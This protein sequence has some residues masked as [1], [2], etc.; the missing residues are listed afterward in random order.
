MKYKPLLASTT[1]LF[2]F[3]SILWAQGANPQSSSAAD[4]SGL[5]ATFQKPP[6]DSR[7]MMRWWWFGSAVTK[8]EI[9]KEMRLMRDGGIGGIEVQPVYPLIPDDPAHGIANLRFLSDEFI[10]ALHFASEKS[11]ELGMRIDLTLGSGWPYGGPDIPIDLAAGRLRCERIRPATGSWRVPLPSMTAGEKIEAIFL[12]WESEKGGTSYV[13]FPTSAVSQGLLYVPAD[14]QGVQEV[15]FFISSRTG[16]QVKRPA[17]GSEGY[18]VDHYSRPAL[19]HYLKTVGDRLLQ[20]FGSRP[21]HAVFCDS[22]EVYLSDWSGDFLQEFSK[23]RGY[24]LKLHLPALVENIGEKTAAVRRD[25]GKTLTE[26]ANE[27]FVAPL[28]DWAKQHG[29]QLRMQCY[30]IPPVTLSSNTL[31]DLPE[32]EGSQWKILRASRWASSASHLYGRPVTSSETWTWLHSPVFRATPLDLKAEADLHF[33]QGINQLIGHGWPYT[34]PGVEYPGWRFYAAGVYNEKNPWWI[35]MPDLSL[36]LQR[37][38]YLLRQGKPSMDIA[39][40][41]PNDDAWASFTSGRVNLLEALGARLGP[42]VVARILEAGYGFDFVD[43]TAIEQLGKVENRALVMGGNRYKMVILPGVERIPLPVFRKLDE[44]ARTGGIVVA[45]RRVPAMAPGM[46][47]LDTDHQEV[48][49]ISQRLFESPSAAGYLVQDEVNELGKRLNGLLRPDMTLTPPAPE[50]GFVH[51][52]TASEEIYFVANSSNRRHTVKAAFRVA[53]LQPEWWDPFTGSATPAEAIA[54][55]QGTTTVQLDLE[56]YGSRILVF[57]KSVPAR[58]VT[59]VA[60]A[61]S[62]PAPLEL[63]EGWNI[64]FGQNEKTQVMAQLRSWTDLEEMRYFSGTATYEKDVIVPQSFLQPGIEVRLDFGEGRA[65]PETPARNGMQAWYEAPV[66]EAAVVFVN[67]QRAGSIWCPPYSV[68]VSGMLQPAVNRLRVVVGNLAV[69]YMS[70][71][72]LPD[73]RLL[74]LRYGSRFDPQDMD[75]IQPVP[76]GLLGPIRLVASA[77]TLGR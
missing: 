10:E 22:L 19:D 41:L 64:W 68:A 55:A 44:L 46:A 77:A 42:H 54:R 9:E 47:A 24:D 39:L 76:S 71:R 59:R 72:S 32:G 16:Q 57:S 35:V 6:D 15:L 75:K 17:V 70:G 43:E 1:L 52:S 28:H 51:R 36:Y 45:T 8:A 73:Y 56:P 58:P 5:R 37:V 50:I 12:T 18:V 67:G 40:Y 23:R 27:R 4:P 14:Y 61:A 30:G 21:P 20:A 63:S 7:I 60:A 13:T 25:W 26:L 29:T 33:I 69:N 53:G 38:S 62:L 3:V 74:N 34:A 66:R 48:R 2:L 65:I 49:Q 11:R 31:V